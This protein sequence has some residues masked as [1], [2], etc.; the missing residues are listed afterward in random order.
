MNEWNC[1]KCGETYKW[2]YSFIHKEMSDFISALDDAA[3]VFLAA[4]KWR[5]DA[6]DHFVITA[7]V[8]K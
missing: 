6:Y 2:V 4:D 1:N 8:L 5:C 7:A 3:N